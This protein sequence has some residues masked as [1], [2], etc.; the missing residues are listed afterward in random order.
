MDTLIFLTAEASGQAQNFIDTIAGF[1]PFPW[2][3]VVTGIGSAVLAV[4]GW[5]KLKKK[6]KDAEKS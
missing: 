1:L 3:C 5:R 2:N 4:F 6:D